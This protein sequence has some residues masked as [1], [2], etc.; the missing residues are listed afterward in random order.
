MAVWNPEANELLLKVLEC[1][2]T[3]ERQSLLD[4]ACRDRPDLRAH[5]EALLAASEK[6]GDFLESSPVYLAE[7]PELSPAAA[8]R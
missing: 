8:Q 5:V 2:S 1:Q 6:A 3:E 4:Q 7:S